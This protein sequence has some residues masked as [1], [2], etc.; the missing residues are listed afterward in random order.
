MDLDN[1][2]DETIELITNAVIKK[3]LWKFK[4]EYH[5]M[6]TPMSVGDLMKGYMPFRETEEEFLLAEMARLHTLLALYEGREEFMKA[7]IIKRRIEIVEN[8]LNNYGEQD[9]QANAGTQI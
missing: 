6:S 3:M 2:N 1:I 9:D 8:R 4:Q 7:A 5:Q